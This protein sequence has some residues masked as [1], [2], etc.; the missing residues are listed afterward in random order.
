MFSDNHKVGNFNSKALSAITVEAVLIRSVRARNGACA[1]GIS[2]S[3][4]AFGF[5]ELCDL[6]PFFFEYG[7]AHF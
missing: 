7:K 1:I 6:E 4:A 5:K 3:A 2:I